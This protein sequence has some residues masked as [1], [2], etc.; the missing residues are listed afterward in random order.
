MDPARLCF[1]SAK[2]LRSLQPL[3]RANLAILMSEVNHTRVGRVEREIEAAQ[4]IG[5]GHWALATG[6]WHWFDSG[7]VVVGSPRHREKHP[8]PSKDDSQTTALADQLARVLTYLPACVY[9][10]GY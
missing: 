8:D 5:T 2:A 9:L 1:V 3:R 7:L 4:E 10:L 6:N